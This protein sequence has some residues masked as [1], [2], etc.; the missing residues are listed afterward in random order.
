MGS[1]TVC[2]I[3]QVFPNLIMP[4]VS[5]NAIREETF[6]RRRHR[7]SLQAHDLPPAFLE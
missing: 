6:C 4:F 2:L 7:L 3:Q 5:S 1:H